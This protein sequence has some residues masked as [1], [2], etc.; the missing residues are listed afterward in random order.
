MSLTNK[1]VIKFIPNETAIAP[2]LTPSSVLPK[3]LV[4]INII[5]ATIGPLL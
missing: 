2:N 5:Y 4:K 3:M 1:Y